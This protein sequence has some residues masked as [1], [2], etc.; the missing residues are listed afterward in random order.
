[1]RIRKYLT[2]GKDRSLNDLPFF[3]SLTKD[4][5]DVLIM[6]LRF[7]KRGNPGV[8]PE[9]ETL[10]YFMGEYTFESLVGALRALSPKG[11]EIADK[12]IDKF[13]AEGYA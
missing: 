8:Y 4:E 7:N 13:E 2:E 6:A 1:M 3:R 10:P 12:L 11:R 9:R 5:L